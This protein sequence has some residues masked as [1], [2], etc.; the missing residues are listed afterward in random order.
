MSSR[1]VHIEGDRSFWIDFLEVEELSDHRVCDSR[2][3]RISEKYDTIF[4]KAR[5]DIIGT[6][7]SSYFID[8]RGDEKV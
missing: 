4:E 6:L 8:D 1:R 7:L 5:V 3:D 2:V